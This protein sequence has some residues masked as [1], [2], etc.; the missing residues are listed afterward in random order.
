MFLKIISKVHILQQTTQ[1]C[2]TYMCLKSWNEFGT[3]DLK[4]G[5][6]VDYIS[7]LNFCDYSWSYKTMI[8]MC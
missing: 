6:K 3:R 2:D 1:F 4:N 5:K 7:F 8:L